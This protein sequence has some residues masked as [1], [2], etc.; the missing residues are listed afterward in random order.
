MSIDQATVRRV[1]QLARITLAE[2]EVEHLRGELNA[3]L[4][5]VAELD[6]VDVEFARGRC[7]GVL[8]PHG[9]GTSTLLRVATG[10]LRPAAG[11]VAYAGRPLAAFD[12]VALARTRAVLSQQVTL[13]FPL[14]AAEVVLLGR[15]PHYGRA[16][17]ARDHRVVDAALARVGLGARRDQPYPT[18]SGG[19]R[20]KVQLARVLAQL[21]DEDAAD[22][23]GGGAAGDPS[24]VLFL[25]E[26]TASL[27]VH[28]QL[29]VLDLARDF[30]AGGGTVVAVL[31]DLNV[32]LRYADRVV[33]LDRGRVVYRGDD[34]EA[35]PQAVLERV[36][37]VRMHRLRDPE[38]GGAVWHVAR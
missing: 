38:S 29:A 11:R 14:T 36:F 7:A 33:V 34:A 19:E 10:L 9:A 1:A 21:W 6:A 3:I 12:P 18:L 23:A 2:G 16:P 4:S 25:D 22:E 20:Q 24:R 13:A 35:V 31:H 15:A 28:D 30:V 37:R 17:R 27:D 26:P 5:F 32:A 8:G